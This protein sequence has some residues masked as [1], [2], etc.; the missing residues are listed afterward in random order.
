MVIAV[1][2]HISSLTPIE[3]KYPSLTSN[4]TRKRLKDGHYSEALVVYD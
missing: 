4:S 2:A 3:T 1:R